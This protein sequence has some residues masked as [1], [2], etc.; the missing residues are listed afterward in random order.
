[1]ISNVSKKDNFVYE[2]DFEG[3]HYQLW[4]SSSDSTN[5][6]LYVNLGGS[7]GWISIKSERVVNAF[8]QEKFK[9]DIQDK[10]M[11]NYSFEVGV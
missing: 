8:K 7:I 5:T 10:A 4:L 11:E 2:F 1:M 3:N 6:L 9:K